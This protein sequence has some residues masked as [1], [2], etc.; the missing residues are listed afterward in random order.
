MNI[1]EKV[2]DLWH[3][4]RPDIR[5][6]AELERQLGFGHGVIATWDKVQPNVRN[7]Q[8]VADFFHVPIES[9]LS[10]DKNNNNQR[11]AVEQKLINM[12]NEHTRGLSQEKQELYLQALEIEMQALDYWALGIRNTRITD[13]NGNDVTEFYR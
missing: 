5:S 8:R 6:L 9:L 4:T 12:Y 3:K 10:F 13:E 2:L 1:K 7:I 11:S